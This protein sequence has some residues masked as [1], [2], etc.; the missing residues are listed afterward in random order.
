MKNK[1]VYE[2]TERDLRLSRGKPFSIQQV[3]HEIV[4]T[5]DDSG[6]K[7]VD[8]TEQLHKIFHGWE[9]R[10]SIQDYAKKKN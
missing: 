8:F 7:R 2:R 3:C 10:E 4:L 9:R 6:R 1:Q 5:I